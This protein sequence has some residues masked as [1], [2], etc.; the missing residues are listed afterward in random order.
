MTSMNDHT[1]AENL[2]GGFA[3]L[4]YAF[5]DLGDDGIL[6]MVVA[7]LGEDGAA[8]PVAVY[9]HDGD[10]VTVVATQVYSWAGGAQSMTV[11]E[12]GSVLVSTSGNSGYAKLVSIEGGRPE[13]LVAYGANFLRDRY[14]AYDADGTETEVSRDEYE[15]MDEELGRMLDGKVELEVASEDWREFGDAADGPATGDDAADA[16]GGAAAAGGADRQAASA[17]DFECEYFYVDV[18]DS[19]E[20]DWSVEGP[21][22]AGN[23]ATYQF[24]HMPADD[25]GGG[26]A[27]TVGDETAPST[28]VVGTTSGGETVVLNEAGAG[29][30]GDDG[31]TIA[32]K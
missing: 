19:W 23:G 15:A 18:P 6:D 24:N 3:G 9:S 11:Y 25:Y 31:A 29:F 2:A 5:V 20:G 22:P 21:I 17:H 14:V 10:E 1:F 16:D 12:D 28:S 13:Q 8:Y 27:V 30:F 26:C 32:L 7:A 4:R